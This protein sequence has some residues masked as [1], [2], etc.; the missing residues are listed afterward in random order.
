[1]TT[2][3]QFLAQ[4][5]CVA[6]GGVLGE[7]TVVESPLVPDAAEGVLEWAE[8]PTDDPPRVFSAGRRTR[9]KAMLWNADHPPGP[10]TVQ[11]IAFKDGTGRWW[12]VG[13]NGVYRSEHA[14]ES[15][16]EQ[17]AKFVNWRL[18]PP[19]GRFVGTIGY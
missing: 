16:A 9:S 8:L 1:M 13:S 17:E 10:Y 14:T 18:L 5:A 15:E 4:A 6:A 19:W 7:K 3:R 11:G 2:R 12:V